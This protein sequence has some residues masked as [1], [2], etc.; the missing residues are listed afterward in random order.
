MIPKSSSRKAEVE[1]RILA[2]IDLID[3]SQACALLRINAD[4]REDTIRAMARN[5]ALI[6]LL[7]D[8][9]TVLPLFQFNREDSRIFDVV[10]HI[11]FIR[12]S[13]VSNLKLTYWMTRAHKD[14]GCAPAHLIGKDDAVVLSAF[15]RYLEMPCHG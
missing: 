15:R 12:P 5:E 6:I 3:T 8:G 2:S 4:D 10:R 9:E 1:K 7:Y 14:F 11:L 13:H